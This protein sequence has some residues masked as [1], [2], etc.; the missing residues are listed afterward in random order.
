MTKKNFFRS[1]L[2]EYSIFFTYRA[3]LFPMMAFIP[4]FLEEKGISGISTGILMGL[5]YITGILFSF[6]AGFLNDRREP[7]FLI[8]VSLVMSGLFYSFFAFADGFVPLLFLFI[9]FGFGRNLFQVSFDSLFFKQIVRGSGCV[10]VGRYQFSYSMAAVAGM[11][12]I[13]LV[14]DSVSF[15]WIYLSVGILYILLFIPASGL[16][17]S[18]TSRVS[19]SDYKRGILKP[20]FIAFAILIFLFSMHWGAEDTCYGLFLKHY[21]G[22]SKGMSS[23]YMLSEFVT[24]GAVSYIISRLV[25]RYNLSLRVIFTAGIII[26]GTSLILKVDHNFYFSMFMRMIHGIGDG[27]VMVVI[28]YGISKVFEVDR[29]GGNM[30]FVTLVLL[31]GSFVGSILFS[32]IGKIDGYHV[33][34]IICGIILIATGCLLTIYILWE[35]HLKRHRGFRR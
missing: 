7:K 31:L 18:G 14:V 6:P 12:L 2:R 17:L 19:L 5:I 15:K 33:S 20:D 11:L 10:H 13:F 27:M 28:Y 30:S 1:H 29:I 34:F 24:L 22:A 26:S 8:I 3:F 16:N 32:R 9:L 4:V 25:D 23:I 35:Y 21:L